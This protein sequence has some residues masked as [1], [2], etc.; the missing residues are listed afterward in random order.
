MP[1]VN[2]DEVYDTMIFHIRQAI[3]DLGVEEIEKHVEHAEPDQDLR[4]DDILNLES[5]AE[6]N[7]GRRKH[8]GV[9]TTAAASRPRRRQVKYGITK[10]GGI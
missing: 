3:D 10:V 2:R 1:V 7:Q 8:S 4:T 9:S 5:D 6:S